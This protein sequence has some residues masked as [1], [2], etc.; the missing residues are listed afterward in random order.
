MFRHPLG[1]RFGTIYL[2]PPAVWQRGDL[3]WHHLL[4][5]FFGTIY[6]SPTVV[7]SL[8]FMDAPWYYSAVP[9]CTFV[10]IHGESRHSRKGR[11]L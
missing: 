2:S 5:T 1:R 7:V 9:S 3:L 11:L 10:L 6:L 4:Y 8:I